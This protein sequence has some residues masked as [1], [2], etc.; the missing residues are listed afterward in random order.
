MTVKRCSLKIRLLR[1]LIIPILLVFSITAI[2]SY[3]STYHE[4][5]EIYDAQL[6]HFA[7][8]LHALSLSEQV[9]KDFVP[10]RIDVSSH[11]DLHKYE[12]NFAYRV[13][14]NQ[15]LI[16]YSSNTEHFGD[17]E[18]HLGFSNAIFNGDRWRLYHFIDNI[19]HITIEVGERFAVREDLIRHVLSSIF[20]PQLFIIPL[21]LAIL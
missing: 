3:I 17:I 9:E 13:W 20:F 15:T 11:L 7:K 4:A 16:L 2:A 1:S 5:E 12:K 18:H 14:L 10:R 19:N 8:V 6:T 21:I